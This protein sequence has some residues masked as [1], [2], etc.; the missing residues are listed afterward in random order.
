MLPSPLA[1]AGSVW[2]AFLLTLV[3]F[4]IFT[5]FLSHAPRTLAHTVAA[6]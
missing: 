2:A 3:G 6:T 4:G 5:S 1:I